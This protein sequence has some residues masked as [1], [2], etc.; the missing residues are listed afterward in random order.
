MTSSAQ[1]SQQPRVRP[2]STNPALTNADKSRHAVTI[3]TTPDAVYGFF[4]NFKNLPL[5]IKDLKSIEMNSAEVSHWIVQL[6]NGLEVEWDAEIIKDIPEK[7]ISWK[8]LAGS[9]VQ[10]NGS[11]FFTKAPAGRGT[12]V[13]L[14]MDYQVPGGKLTEFLTKMMGEDPESLI[15]INLRRLKAYLETGEVPTIEGQPSGRDEDMPME[16]KH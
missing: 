7:E 9:Q 16:S 10:Q 15:P 11:V 5:F 14:T 8:S 4:R 6:D 1:T 12:V 2:K 13:H 3:G